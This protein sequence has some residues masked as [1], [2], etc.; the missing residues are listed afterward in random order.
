MHIT[1]ST[2]ADQELPQTLSAGVPAELLSRRPDVRQAELALAQALYS[3]NSARASFYP[4]VTLSGTLGWTTGN[5]NIVLDPG[6]LITNLIAGLTQPVFGRGVNKARLQAAQ[7]QYEQAGY[8]FRQSLLD[9]GVEVNNALTMWQTAK[10]R[11]EL[12]KKQIV[13]LQ[14]AVW[15]TQLLMKHGNADY[16]EVLTAQKNLLQAELTE[17]SDRLDE[18]KSVINLYRALGGGY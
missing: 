15:N 12:G 10:K 14:A 7:A 2:L 6:S 9:A 17:A 16:L 11:V 4:N 5:G 1:R 18:I 3:V 8:M 13:S